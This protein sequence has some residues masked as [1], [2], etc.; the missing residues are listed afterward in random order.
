MST[1][2]R[3][4]SAMTREFHFTGHQVGERESWVVGELGRHTHTRDAHRN[5]P[6]QKDEQ[7][8]DTKSEIPTTVTTTIA[9]TG[10]SR[11]ERTKLI[12]FHKSD[13]SDAT[14]GSSRSSTS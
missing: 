14:S 2:E 9:S 3:R 10:G 4:A 1:G 8:K 13:T 12:T 7:G 11:A 5:A 6:M